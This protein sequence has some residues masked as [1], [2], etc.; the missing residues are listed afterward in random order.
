MSERVVDNI[1]DLIGGTPIIRL[2][3]VVPEGSAAVW[4]KLENLNPAGSVKE[5]ICLRMIE[6][7]ERSGAIEPGKSVIVEPTSGNTGIGLALVCAVKGYRL[8]LTMPDDMSLER[9][10]LLTAYGAELV[11]TPASEQMG[12]ALRR[13]EE[14]LKENPGSFMPQQFRNR[15]NPAAHRE[16]TGPEIL[17]QMEGGIDAFVAGVGTGGTITG[18]GEILRRKFPGIYIAAVEPEESAVLSGGKPH[19]HEIQGIGAGFVPEILNRGIYD[20]VIRISGKEAKSF[21][22]ELAVKEGLLIGIS[23]GAAGAAALKVAK[24]L[25]KGKNVVTIFCDTGERYLSTGLFDNA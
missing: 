21:A 5:R 2:N 4:A 16:G 14:L 18:V 15:E 8:I 17:E 11:L 13:A 22:R 7:A 3:K 19:V 10:Q 12:G 25:G 1:L 20:E 6:A 23:A 24:K 9:R